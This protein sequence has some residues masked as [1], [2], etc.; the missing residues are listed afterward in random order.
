MAKFTPKTHFPMARLIFILIFANFELPKAPNARDLDEVSSGLARMPQ[1]PPLGHDPGD[2]YVKTQ[3]VWFKSFEI[4]F[5]M[6]F[7]YICP[8]GPFLNP[9]TSE[10]SF[11]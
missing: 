5:G 1:V 11:Q 7:N 4:D 6:K 10:A 9:S 3:K 8:F 2:I